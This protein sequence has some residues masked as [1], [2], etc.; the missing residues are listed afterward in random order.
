MID[1]SQVC[2]INLHSTQGS[3]EEVE[4]VYQ[5]KLSFDRLGINFSCMG[6][7]DTY[8]NFIFNLMKREIVGYQARSYKTSSKNSQ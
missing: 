6:I 4:G 5:H 8:N 7:E 1:L 3:H 2:R